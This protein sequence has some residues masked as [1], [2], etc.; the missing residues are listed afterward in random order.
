MG[1]IY[2][3]RRLLDIASALFLIVHLFQ[4]RCGWLAAVAVSDFVSQRANGRNVPLQE[5]EGLTSTKMPRLFLIGRWPRY[6]KNV[7]GG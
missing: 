7:S 6:C 4:R 2:N 3:V 1:I 5:K